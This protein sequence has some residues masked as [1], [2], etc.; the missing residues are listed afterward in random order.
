MGSIASSIGSAVGGGM[1]L[2]FGP[3]GGGVDN[4]LQIARQEMDP[5]ATDFY[6]NY[7]AKAT[8]LVN[9]ARFNPYTGQEVAP[10]SA[11]Q[12]DVLSLIRNN[13][14]NPNNTLNA[15]NQNLTNTLSGAYL[16]QENP[17]LQK[18]L[19]RTAENF[20]RNVRSPT[21]FGFA[22]AGAFGPEN[23]AY[24]EIT[25]AN[26]S[27]LA[28]SLGQIVYNDFNNR[29]SQERA[30]QMQALGLAPS[31]ANANLPAL[32]AFGNAANIES[33]LAR[34]EFQRKEDFPIRS[35]DPLVTG[36]QLGQG[37]GTGTTAQQTPQ[38]AI[39][40]FENW[41]A[42]TAV[43]SQVGGGGGGGGLFSK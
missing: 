28:D 2:L 15:A 9:N 23:S 38:R 21:D 40:G 22:R 27:A 30:N 13:A 7:H 37:Y 41:M 20:N 10:L 24:N 14:V 36:V 34:Q 18:V 1:G 33:D 35:L 19:D 31:V 43:G 26:N 32:T 11:N 8:D 17:F 5:R 16:N 4:S 29:Y 39:S 42:G 6:A 3:K 12:Q 25:K